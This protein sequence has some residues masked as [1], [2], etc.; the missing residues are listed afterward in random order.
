MTEAEAPMLTLTYSPTSPYVRK[1][2]IVA[3]LL[4]L[5]GQIRLQP[6]NTLDPDDPLVLMNPLGK[7]PA[8]TPDALPP[9]FDSRVIVE[10]LEATHGHGAII[11]ADPVRRFRVLSDA[12]LAEGILDALVLITYEGRFRTP[13]QHSPV[14]TGR[15]MG[16]IRRALIA[17]E[18]ALERFD[19]ISIA[20]ITLACALGYADLRGQIDWRAEMPGLVPWL[21]R[22][23]AATPAFGRSA[24]PVG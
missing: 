23:A 8:L 14:W 5:S 10:Y 24:L 20:A 13:E 11:P 16:K 6:A 22:F 3:D 1:V 21:D 17:A 9:I 18:A 19:G 12:A 4:G 15:Q 7:I 2:R